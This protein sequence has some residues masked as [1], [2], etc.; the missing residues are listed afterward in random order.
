[1][2]SSVASDEF[3][4][5]TYGLKLEGLDVI[6]SYINRA[7]YGYE[8]KFNRKPKAVTVPCK[9]YM[10]I[11]LAIQKG[12]PLYM[13]GTVAKVQQILGLNLLPSTS[14]VLLYV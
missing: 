11:N 8:L 14:L 9:I 13:D 3:N 4:I 1:M 10:A 6:L 12:V 5:P 2:R 7:I